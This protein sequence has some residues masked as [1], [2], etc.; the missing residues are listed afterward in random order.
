VDTP[1]QKYPGNTLE[2]SLV[3]FYE[4][5][6]LKFVGRVGTGESISSR[7]LCGP[8][9]NLGLLFGLHSRIPANEGLPEFAIEDLCPHLEQ[10]VR[11]GLTPSH[12]LLLNHALAHHLIHRGLH[13]AR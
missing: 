6:K 10:V 8:L 5:E 7:G 3:G 4:G 9:L 13:E 2:A 12:L 11:A 1:I